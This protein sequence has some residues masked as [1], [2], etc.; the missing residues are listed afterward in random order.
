MSMIDLKKCL[1]REREREFSTLFAHRADTSRWNA[2]AC[3]KWK[4]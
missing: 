3:L 1:E 4:H 2:G